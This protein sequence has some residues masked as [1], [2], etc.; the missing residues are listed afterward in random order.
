MLSQDLFVHHVYFWLHN[1]DSQKDFNSLMEGLRA[2][3]AVQTIVSFHIGKPASTSRGVIDTSYALSWLLLFRSKED[4]DQYQ[5]DP[6]HLK[7][8]ETCK[9]LWSKVMVYDS[10]GAFSSSDPGF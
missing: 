4:Q 10:I 3:T 5:E 8:V 2:L 6:V 7:F 1:P 9:H